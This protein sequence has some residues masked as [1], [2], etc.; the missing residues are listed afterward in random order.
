MPQAERPNRMLMILSQGNSPRPLTFLGKPELN[1]GTLSINPLLR[2][3]VK[4]LSHS[5]IAVR[6]FKVE[7]NQ[8]SAQLR[9]TASLKTHRCVVAKRPGARRDLQPTPNPP[10]PHDAHAERIP[11]E[12]RGIPSS[13]LLCRVWTIKQFGHRAM[14]PLRCSRLLTDRGPVLPA[15]HGTRTAALLRGAAASCL[16]MSLTFPAWQL[17]IW[18]LEIQMPR[19]DMDNFG[20]PF[21][22]GLLHQTLHSTEFL[23]ASTHLYVPITV[24]FGN[25]PGLAAM[26]P[27]KVENSL[28]LQAGLFDTKP[29]PSPALAPLSSVQSGL[30]RARAR[31]RARAESHPPRA[32]LGQRKQTGP[33]KNIG[34][35]S[36]APRRP[37]KNP[38]TVPGL[39][40]RKP[41]LSNASPVIRGRHQGTPPRACQPHATALP[42]RRIRASTPAL[43]ASK[44][45]RTS[46]LLSTK[47]IQTLREI[48]G[49]AW[50]Q[51]G[52]ER[53]GDSLYFPPRSSGRSE[54]QTQSDIFGYNGDDPF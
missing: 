6:R 1:P 42:A 32:A 11:A 44:L 14:D 16:V 30:A 31:A 51:Q 49:M 13:A 3:W 8:Y 29:R 35:N 9:R 52:D 38:P 40:P 19:I 23:A 4:V 22:R 21:C 36:S 27:S 54:I 2:T 24:G 43:A 28:R 50:Q 26:I 46:G 17:E 41:Y 37:A 25:K 53:L 15:L 12:T 34:P 5:V 45:R 33:V 10:P 47:P 48:H 7:L 18:V 20:E 39:H